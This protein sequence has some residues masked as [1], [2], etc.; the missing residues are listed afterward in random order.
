MYVVNNFFFFG[1]RKKAPHRAR[2][3]RTTRVLLQLMRLR[4]NFDA[5]IVNIGQLRRKRETDIVKVIRDN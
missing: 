1:C 5:P 2:K 3:Q 4:G